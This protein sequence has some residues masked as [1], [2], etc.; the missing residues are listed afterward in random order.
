SPPRVSKRASPP[1]LSSPLT[2]GSWRLLA[3][4][5]D[6]P[7]ALVRER[8][9]CPVDD[10]LRPVLVRRQ[11]GQVNRGP[12]ELSL[13]P[14]HGASSEHLDDRSP[15]ADRRHRA[16]V[17]VLKRLRLLARDPAGDRLSSVLARLERDRPELR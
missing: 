9:P 6:P 12:G 15:A 5:G 4:H 7:G 13:R 14:R 17:S 2:R 8:G 3:F 10:G 11:Q 16:L 1:P